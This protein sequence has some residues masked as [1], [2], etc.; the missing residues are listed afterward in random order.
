MLHIHTHNIV[1][2]TNNDICRPR[3]HGIGPSSCHLLPS[4]AATTAASHFLDPQAD[5]G[6]PASH[7]PL[8]P[9]PD[10]D[11]LTHKG[12]TE[13]CTH[14]VVSGYTPRAALKKQPCS[15]THPQ[16]WSHIWREIPIVTHRTTVSWGLAHARH[17]EEHAAPHR[18]MP[19]THKPQMW[20][21][22]NSI[23]GGSEITLPLPT[24]SF[25]HS[26]NQP[27]FVKH[28]PCARH[29][30]RLRVPS[31][32]QN[33]DPCPRGVNTSGDDRQ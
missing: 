18:D 12:H 20:A 22:V 11:T 26:I 2:D 27:I 30:S 8:H 4:P 6:R 15:Q 16:R 21:Q 31:C 3:A 14:P 29:Y 9:Q 10:P 25:I 23:M 1:G 32:G 5:S 24:H 17:T 19:P 7:T 33:K 28:L 13:S